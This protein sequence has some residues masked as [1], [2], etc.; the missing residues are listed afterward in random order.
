MKNIKNLLLGGFIAL[1]L[2]GCGGSSGGV[3]N[4]SKKISGVALKSDGTVFA[5]GSTVLAVDANGNTAEGSVIDANGKY[6]VTLTGVASSGKKSKL[7]DG[8]SIL[9]VQDGSDE[10]DLVIAEDQTNVNFNVVTSASSAV[11]LGNSGLDL[12]DLF[13]DVEAANAAGKKGKGTISS[14]AV[15]FSLAKVQVVTKEIFK[16]TAGTTAGVLFGFDSTG[17]SVVNVDKLLNGGATEK[18]VTLLKA[19]AAVNNNLLA[20]TFAAAVSGDGLNL[21]AN[22][23][24][25]Q[26]VG[27]L[28]ADAEGEASSTAFSSFLDSVITSSEVKDALN[29]LEDTLNEFVTAYEADPTVSVDVDVADLVED[30]ASVTVA[31]TRSG[32]VVTYS[33]SDAEAN[34]SSVVS[35]AVISSEAVEAVLQV[36]LTSNATGV[37]SAGNADIIVTTGTVEVTVKNTT[38]LSTPGEIDLEIALGEAAAALESAG[39]TDLATKIPQSTTGLTFS[40]SATPVLRGGVSIPTFI[41]NSGETTSSVFGVLLE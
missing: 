10:M 13:D 31:V 41:T 25:Y 23:E 15:L 5:E 21:L 17:K 11:L 26:Q 29:A 36:K 32:D 4:T 6:E 30:A 22:V 1:A 20:D 40:V 7:I 39:Q 12:D 24:L 16:S 2:V 9:R 14:A 38:A 35:V 34:D 33:T 18:E 28:L 27:I 8:N 19:A 37:L 3:S